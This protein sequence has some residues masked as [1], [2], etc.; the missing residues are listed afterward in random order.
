VTDWQEGHELPAQV[1][2]VT[3]A[4]LLRYAAAS[5]DGN[6]IHLDEEFARSVGL[7]GVIAH[8]M[9]TMALAGRALTAWVG[10]PDAVLEFAVRF[11]KPVAVPDVEAGA[12][13][14]VGGLVRTV[15]GPV[16]GGGTTGGR[17]QVDLTVTSGGE[18][19]LAQARATVRT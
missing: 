15:S 12:E 8:G 19:V 6:P 9:F 16:P 18:K 5:G 2:R 17:A 14:V 3:R 13:V 7:P 4:D 10:R 1:Y 11:T